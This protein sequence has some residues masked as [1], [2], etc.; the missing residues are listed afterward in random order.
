M[1]DCIPIMCFESM[2]KR[3]HDMWFDKI[4]IL[5]D[6]NISYICIVY[7]YVFV[8]DIWKTSMLTE[9]YTHYSLWWFQVNKV[10]V[11]LADL[12]RLLLFLGFPKL[13]GCCVFHLGTRGIGYLVC[14][15]WINT[16]VLFHCVW[17][18]FG[19]SFIKCG[20]W[21]ILSK[22]L[23]WIYSGLPVTKLLLVT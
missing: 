2:C 1:S 16:Y 20:Y 11:C 5:I 19:L 17:I 21:M 12:A 15:Y 8:F 10:H 22:N 18:G 23:Q 14:P 7:I 3:L 9:F 6:N 4:M 13:L